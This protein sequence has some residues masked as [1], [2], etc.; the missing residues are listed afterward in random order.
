MSI[1]KIFCTIGTRPEAIKMAP[2]INLLRAQSWCSLT[3]VSTAQH[4]ELLLPIFDCFGFA[5]DVD[6]DVM[7]P[8]QGLSDLLALVVGRFDEAIRGDRP[9]LVLVQGDTTTVLGASLASFHCKVPVGHVEAGLRTANS[10]SP[11][12]EEMNRRLVSR[13]ASYHFAPTDLA[14]GALVAEA[15]PINSIFTVGNTGIDALLEASSK[16]DLDRKAGN[17]ILVT[18]HRRENHGE[19]LEQILAAIAQ[20][21]GRNPSVDIRFPVHPNPNVRGVVHDRLGR[22][23]NVTLLPPLGYPEFVAEMNQAMFILSDSGGVQEEAPALSRPVLVLREET[24][25]P[26]AVDLGLNILVGSDTQRIAREAQRLIDDA[27]AYRA[28]AKGVSP[29]GDGRASQ[30]IC[31]HLYEVLHA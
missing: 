21:A 28:M 17:S 31:R 27:D 26:E 8:G 9:D 19:R 29:Y 4:R 23:G 30:R 16:L 15:I 20:I 22:M 13:I 3:V 14:A 24:E 18:C 2:L 6:L 12:P 5:P 11:F 25:R 7:R 10:Y 1:K